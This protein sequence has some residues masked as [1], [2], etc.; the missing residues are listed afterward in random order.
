MGICCR[1]QST[2][3]KRLYRAWRALL[4]QIVDDLRY[5]YEQGCRRRASFN[6]VL[7]RQHNADIVQQ[8]RRMKTAEQQQAQTPIQ[9]FFAQQ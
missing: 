1:V 8:F 5:G 2:I 3:E 6:E 9:D 4:A 7:A